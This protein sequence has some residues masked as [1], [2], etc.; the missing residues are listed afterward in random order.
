[1]DQDFESDDIEDDDAPTDRVLGQ[2]VSVETDPTHAAVIDAALAD[3]IAQD[4]SPTVQDDGRITFVAKLDQDGRIVVP[5]RFLVKG[6][7]R[8]GDEI[9]IQARKV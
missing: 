9:L 6:V 4:L 8:P 7:L 3:R 1:V 2:D 5:E